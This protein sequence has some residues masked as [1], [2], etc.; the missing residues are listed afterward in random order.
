MSVDNFFSAYNT[1][2]ENVDE[3]PFVAPDNTYNV[4]VSGAEVTDFKKDDG[5]KFF[6]IEYS[7]VGG[8]HA[9]K[10]ANMLFRMTPLTAADSDEYE[11]GNARTLSNYKKALLDL[12]MSEAGLNMFSPSTMGGKLIGIK[13]TARV[14]PSKREGYNNI[15]NFQRAVATAAPTEAAPVVNTGEAEPD[16]D[17]IADLMKG[18]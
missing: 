17:A 15:S 14:F 11:T 2:A 7:I 13:G 9:G 4:M 16:S 12:G 8:P 18:F 10:K 3:N 1:T 6:S 5:P